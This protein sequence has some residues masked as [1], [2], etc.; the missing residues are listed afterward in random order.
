MGVKLKRQIIAVLYHCLVITVV[1][2]GAKAGAAIESE[3]LF[4]VS[5]GILLVHVFTFKVIPVS[6][7]L[8][9]RL[10]PEATC[11][12]CGSTV[13]LVNRYKCGCGFI[14]YKARHVFSPCPFCGKVFLWVVCP[15]CE[16]SI[17]I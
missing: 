5:V 13:D 12:A 4:Q 6:R 15:E 16:T 3:T 1:V 11:F 10:L 14:S 2:L 7:W 9:E 8:Q 17:P